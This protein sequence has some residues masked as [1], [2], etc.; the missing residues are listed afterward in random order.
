MRDKR[1]VPVQHRTMREV[2]VDKLRQSISEGYLV[3]GDKLSYAELAESMNV[4]MTPVREAM[5]TLEALG[6]VT[7]R[8]YRSASV[9]SLTPDEIQ[10][11]YTLRQ[12]VEGLATREAAER[13]NEEQ[14]SHLRQLL[15][16]EDEEISTVANGADDAT[17]PSNLVSLQH[18]NHQFHM[19]IY[20]ASGNRYLCRVVDFLT[21]H[22]TP[23]WAVIARSNMSRIKS[24]HGEHRKILAACEQKNRELADRL[25]QEHLG[26]SVSILV[27][28]AKSHDLNDAAT[29]LRQHIAKVEVKEWARPWMEAEALI[30]SD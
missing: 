21:G 30:E 13:M 23:Y 3:P 14:L 27:E 18:L 24:A 22:L 11:I 10:Q 7:I 5:K 8:S 25:M 26:K 16:D 15:R 28:Y 19:T 1:I 12:A 20:A 17:S 6:L 2:I 4:S 9:S 29:A